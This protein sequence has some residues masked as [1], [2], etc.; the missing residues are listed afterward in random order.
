[1]SARWW[2]V[3]MAL[4]ASGCVS[5]HTVRGI[6]DAETVMSVWT[7]SVDG[8]ER[9]ELRK[10]AV[11]LELPTE[12]GLDI[13]K[14]DLRAVID[15]DRRASFRISK[16][17]DV[18]IWLGITP[19]QSWMFDLLSDPTTLTIG[20]IRDGG[21]PGLLQVDRFRLLMAIDPWP[22]GST[23]TPDAGRFLINGILEGG[24]FEAVLRAEDLRPERVTIQLDDQD[25][26][27]TAHH[28]WYGRDCHVRDAPE[29]RPLAPTVELQASSGE[30]CKITLEGDSRFAPKAISAESLDRPPLSNFFD[31]NRLRAS[32]KPDV[33]E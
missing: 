19:P 6:Q 10:A 7:S 32:L 29:A 25:L 26:S 33:V 16:L 9:L 21:L 23:V 5:S 14:C 2:T 15:G 28:R 18:V 20:K 3:L 27:L 4:I 30:V 11:Q 24:Q 12:D 31:L 13:L 17:G 1:M 8:L 22:A